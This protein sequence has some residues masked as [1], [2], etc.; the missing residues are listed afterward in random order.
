[1]SVLNRFITLLLLLSVFVLGY[2]I[3]DSKAA[4][5]TAN[6]TADLIVPFEITKT[7]DLRFG[8]ISP[9]NTTG[10]VSIS[11]SGVRTS[12]GGVILSAVD[13][14]G[15]ASFTVTGESTSTYAITLPVNW[16]VKMTNG[17]GDELTV[18]DF[19]SN[20]SGT[21]VLT[22]GTQTLTVGGSI[23][24]YPSHATG[25]YTGTF[26]VSVNYN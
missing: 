20:P 2:T 18:N 24:V 1:M 16:T 17:S 4:S 14:G 6:A 23:D 9:G 7:A 3:N 11:A 5:A 10:K 21:G 19:V 8:T 13:A 15:A 26:Q 12:T 22:G 25:S